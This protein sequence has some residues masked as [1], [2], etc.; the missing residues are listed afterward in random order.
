MLFASPTYENAPERDPD[1]LHELHRDAERE[2]ATTGV[3]GMRPPVERRDAG[4]G[5]GFD[6]CT[7]PAVARSSAGGGS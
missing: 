2:A 5:D 1:D 4:P 7:S 3:G 6:G